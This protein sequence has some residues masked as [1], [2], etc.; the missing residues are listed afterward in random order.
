[1]A[2][3]GDKTARSDFIII[4]GRFFVV[5]HSLNTLLLS[6]SVYSEQGGTV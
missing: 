3:E 1:M 5:L 6:I 4:A 2:A